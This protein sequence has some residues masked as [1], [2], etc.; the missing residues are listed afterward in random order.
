[1]VL[2]ISGVWISSLHLANQ[3][4]SFKGWE[5]SLVYLG[6]CW[7]VIFSNHTLNYDL[8]NTFQEL[9]EMVLT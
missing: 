9:L 2:K 6:Y 4:S 3:S 8:R 7:K 5:I 1:M